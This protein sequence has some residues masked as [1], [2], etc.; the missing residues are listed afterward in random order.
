MFMSPTTPIGAC[1]HAVLRSMFAA[2][3]KVF[4]DLL[5][6]DVPALAGACRA[7]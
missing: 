6:W 1:L 7:Y 4:I 2:R 5:K 3:K